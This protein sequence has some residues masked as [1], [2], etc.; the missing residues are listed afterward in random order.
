[1]EKKWNSE[2]IQGYSWLYGMANAILRED[3]QKDKFNAT[4]LGLQVKTIG[5]DACPRT[6]HRYINM[7]VRTFCAGDFRQN[8][9]QPIHAERLDQKITHPGI[10]ASLDIR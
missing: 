7:S 9:I 8:T 3:F 4:S 1:M 6:L 2:L 5:D 10:L